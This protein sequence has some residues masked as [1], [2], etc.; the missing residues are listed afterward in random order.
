MNSKKYVKTFEQFF[1]NEEDDALKAPDSKVYVDDVTIDSGET[2]KAAE[3]LGAITA[4]KT[5]DDF[6]DYFFQNYGNL[7]FQDGE[8]EQLVK[9]YNQYE[10]ER[11]QEETDKEQEKEGEGGGEK[12]PLA[13]LGGL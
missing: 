9:Y 1:L 11:N 5:E 13:G 7:A 2:I 3:I 10:E 6:K 12:D 8:M 4:S